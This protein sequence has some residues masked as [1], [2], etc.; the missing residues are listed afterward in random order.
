MAS[1]GGHDCEFVEKPPKIVQ[2]E[3]PVCLQIIREPHQADCCGY[4]FCQVCIDRVKTDNKPC[5][6]CKAEIFEIFEDK[7]LKR[8]LHDFKVYYSNNNQG[9]KWIGQL[10]QLDSHLNSIPQRRSS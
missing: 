5:P 3:C 8:M 10:K 2:S 4:A 7:R 1:Y 6:C 9:C